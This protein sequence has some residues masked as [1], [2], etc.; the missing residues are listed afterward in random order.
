MNSMKNDDIDAGVDDGV[1]AESTA[2]LKAALAPSPAEDDGM[3]PGPERSLG[4]SRRRPST[5][6]TILIVCQQCGHGRDLQRDEVVTGS[7]KLSLIHI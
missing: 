4:T 1:S 2:D 6:S 5:T 3:H 7:W